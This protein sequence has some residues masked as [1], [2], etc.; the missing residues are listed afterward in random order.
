MASGEFIAFVDSDDFTP[1]YSIEHLYEA[2]KTNNAE[3]AVGNSMTICEG[4]NLPVLHENNGNLKMVCYSTE[5]ALKKMCYAKGFGV[6]PWGKL[7]RRELV[8]ENPYPIG[9]LHEDLALTYKIVDQCKKVV[10]LKEIVY[11]YFQ[12]QDST[13][14]CD[15]QVKHLEDGVRAAKEELEFMKKK[16]PS[17]VQAANFRCCLKV[18]EYIPR[19][20][21]KTK[22]NIEY[23]R[24]LQK[25]IRP[26]LFVTLSDTNVSIAFKVR[27]ITICMGYAPT[28]LLWKLI[29]IIKGRT[30][31]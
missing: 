11:F 21:N 14:H 12:R 19:L 8:V 6:A 3:L 10:E 24:W 29:D 13:M 26:F 2:L 25:E 18:I 27:C 5:E 28:R 16:Y 1:A 23:F 17:V 4:D 31:A 15:I 9:M 7:Y 30:P 22:H 20:L